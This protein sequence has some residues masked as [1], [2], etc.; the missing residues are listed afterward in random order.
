MT[1]LTINGTELPAPTEYEVQ[2]SDIDSSDT[3]RAENGV[4]CRNRIRAG[5]VK[6]S[7]GWSMLTQSEADIILQAASEESFSVQY[8]GGDNPITMYAGDK[9]LH[10]AAIESN[11]AARWNF[12]MNLIE[13]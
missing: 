11:N 1:L 10:L 9:S 12:S 4:M 2:Y 3:G 13:F 5:V 7:A 8:Y 6:I